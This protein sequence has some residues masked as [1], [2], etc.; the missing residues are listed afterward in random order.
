M[1]SRDHAILGAAAILG[2]AM[3]MGPSKEQRFSMASSGSNG[4]VAYR[5][6]RQTG[7][8]LLCVGYDCQPVKTD[9]NLQRTERK[10]SK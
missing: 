9:S 2:V 3:L 7:E 1:D 8:M 5:L 10:D 6:D 4:G